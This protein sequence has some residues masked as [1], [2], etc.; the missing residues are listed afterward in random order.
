MYKRK[1][2]L[3]HYDDVIE[4]CLNHTTI[5]CYLLR[6]MFDYLDVDTFILIVNPKLV[7]LHLLT[8]SDGIQKSD[9]DDNDDDDDDDGDLHISWLKVFGL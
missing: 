7:W 2:E 1:I 3:G 4:T 6:F 5:V 8:Y 9:G